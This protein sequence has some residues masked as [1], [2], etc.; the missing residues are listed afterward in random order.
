MDN[1][2]N[3]YKFVEDFISSSST[4]QDPN[5]IIKNSKAFYEKLM[6]DVN[7]MVEKKDFDG[8]QDTFSN[9]TDILKKELDKVCIEKGVSMDQLKT[10]LENPL[11]FQPENWMALQ[12]LKDDMQSDLPNPKKVKN[13]NKKFKKRKNWASV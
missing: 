12:N 11:N 3:K 1:N 10:L 7:E 5:L 13:K 6:Q 2:N 8:L 4:T 9:V